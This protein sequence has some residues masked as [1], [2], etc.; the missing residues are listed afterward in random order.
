VVNLD[1]PFLG[2]EALESGLVRKHQLR[3]QY[4]ALFPGVYLARGM[5]PTFRQRVE[6]AWLWSHRQ[7]IV[8]GLT[9]ARLYGAKWLSDA[10][11][12]ELVWGN[13]RQPH[14][15]T[16]R[17]MLLCEDETV[18]LSGIPV[19]SLS[20]TAFDVARRRPLSSAVQNLD[21]LANAAQL[22]CSEV[23]QLAFR[24]RG[25]RGLRQIPRALDLHDPGAQSPKETW[26][27]ML[28]IDAGF[29]RPCTQIAVRC[30]SRLYYL[31]MGWEDLMIA[32]EYDGDHHRTERA[33]FARDIVRLEALSNQGWIVIR[34]AADTPPREVLDRLRSAWAAR[35]TSTLR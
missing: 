29:P 33:Q 27:R 4:V 14:G 10:L 22:N 35:R 19:T 7:G 30:G 13:A 15:I 25:A 21:A 34:V 2:V 3:S 24:H 23:R 6:A 20:R 1:D 11:P 32:L 16:T 26:L 31:D 18:A 8:A 12:I 9:A 28:V 5:A 17:T